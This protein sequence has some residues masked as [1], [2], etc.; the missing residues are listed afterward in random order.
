MIALSS[1]KDSIIYKK[2]TRQGLSAITSVDV[3][4]AIQ[5]IGNLRGDE[6]REYLDFLVTL[7]W[8]LS[9]DSSSGLPGNTESNSDSIKTANVDMRTAMSAD[10]FT[11]RLVNIQGVGGIGSLS[12]IE[13]KKGDPLTLTVAGGAGL[14][15]IGTLIDSSADPDIAAGDALY[16]VAV[17]V[18]VMSGAVQGSGMLDI[19][20]LN[21][22]SLLHREGVSALEA[23]NFETV[24]CPIGDVYEIANPTYADL[25]AQITT[26]GPVNFADGDKIILTPYYAVISP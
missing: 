2:L 3:R 9:L 10:L 8:A 19:T 13:I 16:L 24:L 7:V 26:A 12:E 20:A 23:G 1:Y 22:G 6:Q 18:S 21:T 17:D 15:P 25:R 14:A 5:G 11:G 4:N